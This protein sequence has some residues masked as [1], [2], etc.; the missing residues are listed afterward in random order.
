MARQKSL[1]KDQKKNSIEAGDTAAAAAPDGESA[2]DTTKTGGA[3]EEVDPGTTTAKQI[4]CLPL[5]QPIVPS[6]P[7]PN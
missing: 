2:P 3:A 5:S 6:H 7:P 4:E 1:R